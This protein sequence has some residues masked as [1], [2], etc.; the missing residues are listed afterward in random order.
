MEHEEWNVKEMQ[1]SFTISRK[2]ASENLNLTASCLSG[3]FVFVPVISQT[4]GH[5]HSGLDIY[6]EPDIHE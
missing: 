1:F 5:R 6:F 4:L 3:S 2:C